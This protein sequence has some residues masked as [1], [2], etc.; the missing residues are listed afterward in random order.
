MGSLNYPL[1]RG[2]HAIPPESL[3]TR[4]DAEVDR[5]ISRPKPVSGEKNVWFFWHAGYGAMH[6]YTK[7]NV[8]AWHRRLAKRGWTVR[9]LDRAPGSPCN[10]ANFLDVSDPRAFPRAFADGAVRGRYAAQHVS[11]LVRWPLLLRYGGVYADVGLLQIGDLDRLWNETVADPASPFE[12]LSYN[13]NGGLAN[14][15]LACRAGN[16]FFERCHRLF[17]ALWAEDG[18]KTST[19]GMHASPLLKGAPLM[20]SSATI[21]EDG[22]TI[23]PD[24]VQKMLSDYIVQGQA[25]LM[26]M[27]LV[28]DE[29][30]WDGPR[31]AADHIYAIDYMVG[32]QLINEFTNWDGKKAFELMSLPLPKDG[33]IESAEQKQAREIVEA[34]LQKSFGF[35]LA[36]GLIIRVFRYTLGSLWRDHEGSDDVPGTYAHWLRHA[37]TYWNQDELPPALRFPVIEPFKRGPLLREE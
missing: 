26:V 17:L 7:R 35:K 16:P 19:D 24:K 4:P 27:G 13:V 9:V 25:T 18:G 20:S 23:G 36:H 1:P 28:D 10:V 37:T 12:V 3:D 32:S 11:D 15:F 30:G 2:L 31:Y 8:R 29:D 5:D 6:P 33:E 21:Q 34:C 14:Y 22:N